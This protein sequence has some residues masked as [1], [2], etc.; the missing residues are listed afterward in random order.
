MDKKTSIIE[1]SNL[2]VISDTELNE[3]VFKKFLEK[4]KKDEKEHF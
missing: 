3:R 4:G 1:T 2:N